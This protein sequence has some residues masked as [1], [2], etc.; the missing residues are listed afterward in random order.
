VAAGAI[1]VADFDT[2]DDT[3]YGFQ[4]VEK[5]TP[6]H[7]EHI[8]VETHA[9]DATAGIVSITDGTLTYATVEAVDARAAHGHISGSVTDST[10]IAANTMIYAKVTTESADSSAT[11]GEGYF[12]V[13][14]K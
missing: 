7:V 4:T 9:C 5:I 13:F 2:V 14:Y 8:V 11:A 10:Y 1:G 12:L 3:L 6:T